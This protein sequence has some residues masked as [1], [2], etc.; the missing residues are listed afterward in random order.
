M[1]VTKC[2]LPKDLGNTLAAFP[3]RRD[4]TIG[5]PFL[6]LKYPSSKKGWFK[7][8]KC[9]FIARGI[10]VPPP[11]N[12]SIEQHSG[13][14]KFKKWKKF[15]IQ[16]LAKPIRDS[17]I[18]AGNQAGTELVN[19]HTEKCLKRET[20]PDQK[21]HGALGKALTGR[22]ESLSADRQPLTGWPSEPT[23]TP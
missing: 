11:S 4:T 10:E 7:A 6:F 16:S 21:A 19:Q 3:T 12:A 2:P 20:I 9:L 17:R 13:W 8:Y 14:G 23:F 5:A 15:H 22:T 1:V 18:T